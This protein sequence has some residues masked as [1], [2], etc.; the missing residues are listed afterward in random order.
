[1]TVFWKICLQCVYLVI[2]PRPSA[3]LRSLHMNHHP[4]LTEKI[5]P[6]LFVRGRDKATLWVLTRK[7]EHAS[8]FP[9]WA[10]FQNFTETLC[11]TLFF[12]SAFWFSHTLWDVVVRTCSLQCL[13]HQIQGTG[14]GT[15]PSDS[16][17]YSMTAWGKMQRDRETKTKTNPLLISAKCASFTVRHCRF[18]LMGLIL[19]AP[20]T[21]RYSTN[22]QCHWI[23][24]R[25]RRGAG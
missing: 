11:V 23:C 2:S 24:L 22:F 18:K 13:F 16:Q 10:R 12:F 1:M 25:V 19:S 6:H 14:D 9:T 17:A 8:I 15:T 3:V 21:S 20:K 4:S 5:P 7:N